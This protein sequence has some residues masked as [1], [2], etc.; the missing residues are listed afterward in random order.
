MVQL[1]NKQKKDSYNGSIW[2]GNLGRTF[3]PRRSGPGFQALGLNVQIGP[4]R[5]RII[6]V[7]MGA[8]NSNTANVGGVPVPSLRLGVPLEAL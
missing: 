8:N 7:I 4:E 6:I 5:P 2:I 1:D 3:R